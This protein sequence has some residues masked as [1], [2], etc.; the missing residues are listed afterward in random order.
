MKRNLAFLLEIDIVNNFCQFY[1]H[2]FL[3]SANTSP[4]LD[5][6]LK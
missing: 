5:N 2:H 1:E 3:S 4:L 6:R